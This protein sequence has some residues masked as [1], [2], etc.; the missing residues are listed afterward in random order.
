MQDKKKGRLAYNLKVKEAF[1]IR[2]HDCGPGR[3]LNEDNGA[4][5]KTDIWDPVLNTLDSWSTRM[6]REQMGGRAG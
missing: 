4:Y 2:R 3:G 6:K 5:L 1:E